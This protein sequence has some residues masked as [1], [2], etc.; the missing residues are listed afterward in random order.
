MRGI[1]VRP[2]GTPVN[3]PRR[4]ED[5][6]GHHGSSGRVERGMAY[7]VP[8]S[9]PPLMSSGDQ[10]ALRL[11]KMVR[12]AEG[13]EVTLPASTVRWLLELALDG[14]TLA[15]AYDAKALETVARFDAGPQESI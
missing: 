14:W 8:A 5:P 2:A 11:H 7:R 10:T 13:G 3:D 9:L 4:S 1:T 6:S 15:L 12:R